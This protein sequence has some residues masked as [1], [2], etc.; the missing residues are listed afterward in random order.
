[1]AEIIVVDDDPKLRRML[2]EALTAAGH[3]VRTAAGGEELRRL[4]ASG[5]AAL[6]VLDV[7]L[8]G[9]DGFRLARWLR[10]HHDPGIIMLTGADTVIDRVVGLETGAD[11]YLAKPCPLAELKA[12]IAAV[13]RRR[14]PPGGERLPE[15]V[16]RFGRYRFDRQRFRLTD[17]AGVEVP[18]TAMELDLVAAFA[19][20]PRRVLSRDELMRLAPPRDEEGFDRSIDSRVHRLRHKLE[21][22]PARPELIK[23]L[24]SAGYVHPG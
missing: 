5:P 11:D 22:D 16:V 8:P 24:R 7:G 18:L 1:M 12:R 15:G 19:L 2:A 3:S 23:T 10:E 9:E 4:L 14:S 13:L 20:H 17:A 21:A 6:V